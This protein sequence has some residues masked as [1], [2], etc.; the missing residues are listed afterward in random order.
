VTRSTPKLRHLMATMCALAVVAPQT[1]AEKQPKPTGTIK[2]LENRDVQV[3]RDPPT[4]ATQQQAIE[5][6]K[7]FLELQTDNQKLRAEA[8]RRLGDLQVEV[9]EASRAGGDATIDGMKLQDAVKLYEGLLKAYPDYARN[10]AVMYQLA[11][12]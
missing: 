8:M 1:H 2:D 11:R 4:D 5:Q 9:D 7:R 12:A 3:H 6:Y 10:D